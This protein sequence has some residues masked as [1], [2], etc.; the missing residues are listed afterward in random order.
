MAFVR[1]WLNLVGGS[2]DKC[3]YHWRKGMET[4]FP[5]FSGEAQMYAIHKNAAI[6]SGPCSSLY[7]E[8][9]ARH[10]CVGQYY[11]SV[12]RPLLVLL[13]MQELYFFLDQ[14]NIPTF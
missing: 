11:V 2:N 7:M 10:A 14:V 12:H 1:C 4:G 9:D 6:P 3:Y 8:A 5:A 13:K